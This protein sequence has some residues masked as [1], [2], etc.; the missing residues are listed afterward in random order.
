MSELKECP[1]CGVLPEWHQ[2]YGT[3][4]NT[5]I[6]ECPNCFVKTESDMQAEAVEEW[7]NRPTEDK[8]RARIAELEAEAELGNIPYRETVALKERVREL[9]G[10]IEQAYMAGYQQYAYFGCCSSEEGWKAFK[11]KHGKLTTTEGGGDEC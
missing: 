6:L 4:Y 5:F 3:G 10:L 11:E 9:D 7:N 8:L 1:F 2:R